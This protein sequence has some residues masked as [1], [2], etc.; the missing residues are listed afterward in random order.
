VEKYKKKLGHAK[1][2]CADF[3]K[4]VQCIS[5]KA[6][7]L[8]NICTTELCKVSFNRAEIRESIKY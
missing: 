7:Y 5:M 8:V 4:S 3:I 6:Y 1:M 2:V